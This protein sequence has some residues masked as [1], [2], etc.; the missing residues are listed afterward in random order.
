MGHTTRC[1]SS[2]PLGETHAR[3]AAVRALSSRNNIVATDIGTCGSMSLQERRPLACPELDRLIVGRIEAAESCRD[4]NYDSRSSREDSR[5]NER[6]VALALNRKAQPVEMMPPMA[7][8]MSNP[9]AKAS[10][11]RSRPSIALPSRQTRHGH[12][13]THYTLSFLSPWG[14][15]ARVKRGSEGATYRNTT[16]AIVFGHAE[17]CPSGERRARAR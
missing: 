11:L 3:S 6:L 17:A 13:G 10:A 4:E 5:R 8:K 2:L 15:D 14:R 9:I 12:H 7:S 1:R 16:V